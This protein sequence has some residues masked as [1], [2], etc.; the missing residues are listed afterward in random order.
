MAKRR[1]IEK[2]CGITSHQVEEETPDPSS[3][4]FSRVAP[5]HVP[6]NDADSQK[7]TRPHKKPHVLTNIFLLKWSSLF[8][9]TPF[10][11]ENGVIT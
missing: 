10:C 7:F 11:K 2:K 3:S 6:G 9:S 8:L 5:V 1:D 4:Y